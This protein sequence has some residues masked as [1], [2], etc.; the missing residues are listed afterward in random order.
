MI[1][2]ALCL[3]TDRKALSKEAVDKAQKL[4]SFKSLLQIIA[5]FSSLKFQAAHSIPTLN[6]QP[7]AQ[8]EEL[9]IRFDWQSTSSKG[10]VL[11]SSKFNPTKP[12][13]SWQL[14]LAKLL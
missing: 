14:A 3:A 4:H 13:R 8:A 2:L 5:G 12:K 10:N 7:T 1:L 11:V 9:N 6:I